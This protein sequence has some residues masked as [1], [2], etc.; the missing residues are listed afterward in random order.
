MVQIQV[1]TAWVIT[2]EEP[3][4]DGQRASARVSGGVDRLARRRG[5]T[6]QAAGGACTEPVRR[7][8]AEGRLREQT[9]LEVAARPGTGC[10]RTRM[11]THSGT[12]DPARTTGDAG[13]AGPRRPDGPLGIGCAVGSPLPPQRGADVASRPRTRLCPGVRADRAC[14]VSV[15]QGPGGRRGTRVVPPALDKSSSREPSAAW[16]PVSGGRRPAPR[17]APVGAPRARRRGSPSAPRDLRL[18]VRP[19]T[20]GSARPQLLHRHARDAHGADRR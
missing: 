17:R 11:V 18:Y 19:P 8:R 10:R 7:R 5:R 13:Q 14:G 9:S 3:S 16:R 1:T 20:T 6:P 4:C 15:C 12:A 2:Y